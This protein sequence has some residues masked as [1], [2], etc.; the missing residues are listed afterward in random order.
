MEMKRT[1]ENC[2]LIKRCIRAGIGEPEQHPN[3]N[4]CVG[5]AR[6]ENDDEPCE[7][8]KKCKLCTSSENDE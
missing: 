8:C 3:L 6:S 5:Y 1:F 7:K 4:K 2:T